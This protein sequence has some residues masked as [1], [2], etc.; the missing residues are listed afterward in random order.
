VLRAVT[1]D[2]TQPQ[3]FWGGEAGDGFTACA[4]SPMGEFSIRTFPWR[5]F[6]TLDLHLRGSTAN[7]RAVADVLKRAFRISR[8]DVYC[9]ERGLRCAPLQGAAVQ[10]ERGVQVAA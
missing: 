8:A 10:R 2:T 4:V 5:G 7:A 1:R 6:M 9:Q 3:V